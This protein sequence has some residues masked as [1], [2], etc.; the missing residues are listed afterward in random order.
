MKTEIREEIIVELDNRPGALAAVLDR[1]AQAGVNALAVC[2]YATDGKGAVHVVPDQVA[3]AKE[4]LRQAGVAF[5]TTLVVVAVTQDVPGA[6][7]EIARRIA[8]RGINL[9][10]CYATGIGRGEARVVLRAADNAGAKEAL[11]A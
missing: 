2:A 4:A 1:L 8:E 11:G 9:E 10:H 3:R 7:A 5:R 6:A